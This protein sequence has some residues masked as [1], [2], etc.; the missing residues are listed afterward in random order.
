M[1][2]SVLLTAGASDRVAL[3]TVQNIAGQSGDLVKEIF[4][5]IAGDFTED[6]RK[7]L[8]LERASAFGMTAFINIG[9]KSE[10][11]LLNTFIKYANADYC[12]VMRAGGKVDPS[13][14]SRLTAALDSDPDL[15]IACGRLAGSGKNIFFPTSVRAAVIDLDKNFRL[16]PTAFEAVV[17]RTSFAAEHHFETEA[18]DFAQ[19]KCM[20]KALCEQKKFFYD[21]RLTAWLAERKTSPAKK[22]TIPENADKA[23]TYSAIFDNCLIPLAETC[24]GKDGRLPLFLQHFIT[25]KVMECNEKGLRI[26]EFPEDERTK[27]TDSLQKVLR[28]AEDKVICD[29]YGIFSASAE[30]KRLLLGLKHGH[31]NYFPDISYNSDRLFSVQKDIVLFDSTRLF[32]EIVQLNLYKNN[33]EIDGC[34]D[35]IFSERRTK[36]T[37][38]YAGEEYKLNYDR[39]GE[40]VMFFGKKLE[41][42]RTFHMSIPVSEERAELR[43]FI[44]FKGCKYELRTVFRTPG[45]RIEEGCY[46]SIF[47]LGN[48]FFARAENG[49]LVTLALSEKAQ[50]RA[51]RGS[52]KRAAEEGVPFTLRTA[53]RCTRFWFKNKN[54]WL[55]ADDTQKG[56]GAA[57]DMF[58]YA[59]TR[60][61][62]LYCYYLTDKESPAAQRIIDDGYKPLY[63]GT[64]LHKLIFLNAQVYITTVPDI[65]QKNFPGNDDTSFSLTRLSRTTNVF[66][67]NSPEDKPSVAKNHR[68]YDNVRLYFCGTGDC[69]DELRKPEY[70]YENTEVLKL[71]GLTSFDLVTDNS[72]GSDMLLMLA[73]YIPEEQAPFKDTGFFGSMKELLE[74]E[75]LKTALNDSGYT[76]TIAF[77]GV[78]NDEAKALPKPDKVT[79]LTDDFSAEELKSR[80]SLIVTDDPE[81]LSAGIMRKPLIYFGTEG[82]PFGEKAET[83]EQLADI[84]CGYIENGMDIKEEISQKAD[85]Y[86][87]KAH[88]GCKREIYNN[89]IT[90]LYD[91]HEIDGYE[92]FEVADNYDEENN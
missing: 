92:D 20:L 7:K 71:T 72:E 9:G 88:D 61:D 65:Q 91:N 52:M 27:L 19:Q 44:L 32:I 30:E 77:E 35:N 89:I 13:Y 69:I 3:D 85:E 42:Q 11:E 78:T 54:I 49:R 57:E 66:L 41:R 18:G 80:A 67:Q 84:L 87:G 23:E 31:E 48:N 62:E 74:N 68:L 21:D 33:I 40:P 73:K 55:F 47:P 83:P 58:R 29:V 15:N 75:K 34:F 70:G 10:A 50:R 5:I 36:L 51:F 45:S 43:F 6:D 53:Y 59:M 37:A 90:Y 25:A 28:P 38:E 8:Y 26:N 82:K 86:L 17:V 46:E 22:E 60:H 1:K 4:L 63:R 16:F 81:E 56:G 12:T 39:K 2:L 64:L 76:L 79:F 14:F 24:K